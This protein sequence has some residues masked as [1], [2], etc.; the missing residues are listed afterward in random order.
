MA[1]SY[2]GFIK[3]FI[4]KF[5]NASTVDGFN[6][7]RITKEGIDWELLDPEDEWSNIGYW[8]DHQIIYLL[9]FLELADKFEHDELIALLNTETY[10]YANVPYEICDVDG[11]FANPKDTVNF[12]NEK[13]SL[14]ERK[15]AE[16][17]S[18]GKLVLNSDDSVYMVNLL[19]KILVP[20]LSKLSNLVLDGGIWLNTQRPE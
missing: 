9:K 19:E 18:D 4:A 12:N 15:V 7:Y 20:L 3:S 5:V 2:P 11:L 10:S 6:P 1:L 17:G 8:G 14:I 16:L 13:Q